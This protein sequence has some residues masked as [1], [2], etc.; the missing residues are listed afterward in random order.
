MPEVSR[1]GSIKAQR[2]E[3]DNHLDRSFTYEL[4]FTD[5]GAMHRGECVSHGQK[6]V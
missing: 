1:L 3:P 2:Q 5:R 6:R 4:A